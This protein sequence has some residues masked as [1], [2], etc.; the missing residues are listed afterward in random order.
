VRRGRFASGPS[1]PTLV[2]MNRVPFRLLGL[3]VLA[4]GLLGRPAHA[5]DMSVSSVDDPAQMVSADAPWVAATQ[6]KLDG[7]AHRTGIR[8][9]VQF[10]AKSPP[11][12]VDQVAGA[13]MSALSR[14][15]GLIQH[16]VL[17][18]YF[19]D[20]PDWRIWVGDLLTP[21]FVGKPGDAASLT[22]SGEMHAAK[23]AFLNA[24]AA[25]A[26]AEFAALQKSGASASPA[27]HLTLHA[28][29]LV[30]GLCARLASR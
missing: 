9:V 17:V 3:S 5:A 12:D 10:H 11:A 2:P 29:A 4:I 7:F 28:D 6:A 24:A 19:A 26:D 15:L 14:R 18:V 23:E 13:Y 25:K 8:I 16:G 20:D 22:K 27:K 30:D 21:K 1:A